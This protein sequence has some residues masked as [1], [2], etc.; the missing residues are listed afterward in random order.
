M[1][2]LSKFVDSNDRELRRLQP[3]VDEANPLVGLDQRAA[4]LRRLG[5][6]VLARLD[7]FASVD[8]PRPGGLRDEQEKK[9]RQRSHE[10]LEE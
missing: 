8:A 3:V 6:Q 9:Q 10:S 1:R 2:F 5:A 7:L 4:L